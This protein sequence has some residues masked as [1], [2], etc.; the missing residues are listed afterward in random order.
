MREIDPDGALLLAAAIA[1][2]WI[3]EEPHE[4]PTVA[5]WLGIDAHQL[6]RPAPRAVQAGDGIN[7]CR[8]CGAPL[9]VKFGGG[10]HRIWCSE[11]CRRRASRT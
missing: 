1:R 11:R 3:R 10:R 8:R 7:T 2:Q 9:P 4:L 5:A 6:R